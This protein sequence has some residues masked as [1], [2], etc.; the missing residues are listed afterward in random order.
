LEL[1]DKTL[2]VS[3]DVKIL[4]AKQI[5]GT[6]LMAV[7]VE[8]I[9]E[10][11]VDGF[12][13]PTIFPVNWND[14]AIYAEFDGKPVGLIAYQ[15]VEWTMTAHINLTYV[16]PQYRGC[17]VFDRMYERLLSIAKEA[18]MK[19]IVGGIHIHNAHMIR[20]AQRMGRVPVAVTYEQEID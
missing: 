20:A 12:G 2:A 5:S 15:K 13:L 8:A 7:A 10:L 17:G 1:Q 11:N 14:S 3:V 6:P 19:R 18:G 9:H 4:D 16:S